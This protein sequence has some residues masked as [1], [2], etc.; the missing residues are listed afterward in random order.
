M[1]LKVTIPAEDDLSR[2]HLGTRRRRCRDLPP[3]LTLDSGRH[4]AD[5]VGDVPE[6]GESVGIEA[7]GAARWEA[8]PESWVQPACG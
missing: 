1:A 6:A 4:L 8:H 7:A 3:E 2:C 5:A